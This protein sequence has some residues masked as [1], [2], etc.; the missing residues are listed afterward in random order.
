MGN[1]T[2]LERMEQEIYD[3][4]ICL[5]ERRPAQDIDALYIRRSGRAPRIYIDPAIT[6]MRTRY[7]LL[8]EELAHHYTTV[9]DIVALATPMQRRQERTAREYAYR[10][11]APYAVIL[12]MLRQNYY[13]YE[14]ADWLYVPMWYLH[15]AMRYYR[16]E[17]HATRIED[18]VC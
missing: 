6:S 4:G 16:I 5:I 1:L 8:G 13:A 2:P 11:L 12:Q 7:V 18:E 15:D 3:A 10:R 17:Q 14:I 9:G